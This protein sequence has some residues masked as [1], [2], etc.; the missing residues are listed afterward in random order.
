[1]SEMTLESEVQPEVKSPEPEVVSETPE[2]PTYS[3]TQ[4][5]KKSKF[6][7]D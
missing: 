2:V 3:G 4:Q 5:T 6:T 7:Y 1:M